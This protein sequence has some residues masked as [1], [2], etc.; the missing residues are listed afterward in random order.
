MPENDVA[1]T[2]NFQVLGDINLNGGINGIDLAQLKKYTSN[3]EASTLSAEAIMV[4]NVAG[5][6]N[7]V[8]N[9]IDLAQLKKFTANP[10]TMQFPNGTY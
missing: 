3:P 2:V 10:D 8:I 7:T 4:A 1:I 6:S 5:T 9:G